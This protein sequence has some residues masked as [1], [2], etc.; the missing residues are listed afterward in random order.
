MI[1]VVKKI[2]FCLDYKYKKKL[3]LIQILLFLA[4]IFELI[5]VFS[6][7]PLIQ[8]LSNLEILNDSSVTITKFYIFLNID[9]H[10]KFL[11]IISISVFLIFFTNFILALSTSYIIE[12]FAQEF[13]NFLK[14]KVFKILSLQSWLD[15]SRRDLSTYVNLITHE[16]SRVSQNAVLPLMNLNAKLFSGIAIIIFIFIYNPKI[17][18]I[19]F[20]IFF[21]SYFIIFK[22]V[23]KIIDKNGIIQ[24]LTSQNMYKKIFETFGGIKDTI[25]NNKQKKF[26]DLLYFEAKKYAQATIKIAFFRNSPK[27]FLEFMAFSIIILSIILTVSDNNETNFKNALPILAVYTFAGYKLLPV[28]QTI[29]YGLLSVRSSI[30]AV[31][32]IYYEIEGKKDL[33]FKDDIPLKKNNL[34]FNNK[35]ELKNISFNYPNISRPAVKKINMEIPANSIISIVGASGSGKSTILDIILGLIKPKIGEVFIDEK[36]LTPLIDHFQKKISYVAQNIFLQNESIKSNICFGLETHEIDLKKLEHAIEA[37]NLNDLIKELPDG[38]ETIIG[39]RGKKLSGGQQQRIA[40]ARALYLDRDIIILDEATSSLDGISEGYIFDKLQL[41]TK[42][43]KKTIILVTHNINLTRVSDIIYL[44][45]K[46]SIND[47]GTFSDLLKNDIFIKLL[48][49]KK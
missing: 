24:S 49:E 3:F 37:S 25:L 17:T 27:L 38:V 26:Y 18:I 16:T 12:K 22:L 47:K 8:L 29:Y 36:P 43:Y 48:N 42:K 34:V 44:I 4:A 30:S 5:T 35:I 15:H 10:S 1:N 11:K 41:F 28:F 40:I 45:D 14:M 21:I 39:E 31:D 19:C 6:V 9:S 20:L 13:G 32:R 7:A 33:N 2:Y 23:K 46:G